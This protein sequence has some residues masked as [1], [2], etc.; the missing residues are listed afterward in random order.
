MNE[1]KYDCTVS[2]I[3]GRS[4]AEA[5]QESSRSQAFTHS[6]LGSL[7]VAECV[8]LTQQVTKV[9]KENVEH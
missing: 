5:K 9:D 6:L 8:A 4:Q 1:K 2:S 3:G 7:A